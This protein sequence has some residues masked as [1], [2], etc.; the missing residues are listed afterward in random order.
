LTTETPD[1][2][3]ALDAAA[4][5]LLTIAGKDEEPATD[6]ETG[7]PVPPPSIGE[8]V[9]AFAE[10]WKYVESRHKREPAKPG[11]VTPFRQL[12]DRAKGSSK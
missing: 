2:Y 4:I 7:K 9:K 6:A 12:Q 8:R 11:T 10:V 5:A 1:L 3:A